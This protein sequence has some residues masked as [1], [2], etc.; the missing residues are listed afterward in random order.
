M[1]NASRSRVCSASCDENGIS[2]GERHNRK[3]PPGFERK[4]YLLPRLRCHDH[5]ELELNKKNQVILYHKFQNRSY[6][7]DEFCLILEDNQF[8]GAE[9]CRKISKHHR[10]RYFLFVSKLL[11]V[12]GNER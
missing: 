10:F 6:A 5:F 9:V 2:T 12:E 4:P 3:C 1:R 7:P 8:M 11:Y